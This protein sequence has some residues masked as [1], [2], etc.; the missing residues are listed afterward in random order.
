MARVGV[1]TGEIVA[2][3]TL[4]KRRFRGWPLPA[5]VSRG[6]H[7]FGFFAAAVLASVVP[8]VALPGEAGSAH[9]DQVTLTLLAN[10]NQ[11]EAAL[12]TAQIGL[13][14]GQSTVDGILQAMDAAWKQ[15]P[16]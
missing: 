1:N 4:T 15:G 2:A 14:T 9:A 13:V 12:Q 10:G 5:R 16:S 7:R 11:V 3:I 8:A 6:R